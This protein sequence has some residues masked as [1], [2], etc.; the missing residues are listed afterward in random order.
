MQLDPSDIVQTAVRLCARAVVNKTFVSYAMLIRLFESADARSARAKVKMMRWPSCRRDYKK[1][2][3]LS[4]VG[5]DAIKKENFKFKNT[6]TT[7]S[8]R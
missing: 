4:D 1:R 8:Q 6:N 3:L 7:L 5:K 2:R